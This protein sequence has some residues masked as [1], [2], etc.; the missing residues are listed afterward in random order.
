MPVSRQVFIANM[1]AARQSQFT[2]LPPWAQ[3]GTMLGAWPFPQFNE[4]LGLLFDLGLHGITQTI[5]PAAMETLTS[6]YETLR[7]WIT[8]RGVTSEAD[9]ADAIE[10]WATENWTGSVWGEG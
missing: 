7:Q 10:E 1:T 4:N 3:S 2:Q 8:G 6:A 9:F 5:L